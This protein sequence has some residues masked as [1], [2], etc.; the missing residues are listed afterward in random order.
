MEEKAGMEKIGIISGVTHAIDQQLAVNS[1]L[2]ERF[3][4]YRVG[5]GN[6][7]EVA[8][9]AMKHSTGIGSHRTELREIVSSFLA[10][11]DT[12]T[13]VQLDPVSDE[14]SDK[15]ATLAVFCATARTTVQRNRYNQTLA[16]FPEPEGPARLAKQFNVLAQSLAIVKGNQNLDDNIYDTICKLAC[17]SMPK[18]RFKV[19][20]ELWH[21]YQDKPEWYTTSEV[22][23][24][25]NIPKRT[26]L[27]KLEDLHLLKLAERN[28]G[29]EDE[30]GK[31]PYR[32]CPS[33]DMKTWMTIT[34]AVEKTNNNP[35][36]SNI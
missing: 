17:D 23:E 9:T 24:K 3:L 30:G 19:L 16:V 29:D 7:M 10:Q 25:A 33:A 28:L 34:E 14:I 18:L 26:V 21:L 35:S 5:G 22:A 2:G 20:A 32:W 11:L 1:L 31:K 36:N 6:R 12:I 15:I 13:D 4:H 27:L 8:K